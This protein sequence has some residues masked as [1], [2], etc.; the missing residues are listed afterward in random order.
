MLRASGLVTSPRQVQGASWK[1]AADAI[2]SAQAWVL[3]LA[4]LGVGGYYAKEKGYLDSF[5]NAP[6]L[7]QVQL[8]I[9]AT[10][11]AGQ[12]VET[13]QEHVLFTEQPTRV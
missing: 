1:Q 6:S 5:L 13:T 3:G 8:Y 7:P 2:T 10:L 12:H 4:G 9:S 11:F